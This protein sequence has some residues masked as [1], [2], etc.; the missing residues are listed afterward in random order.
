MKYMLKDLVYCTLSGQLT[1]WNP[2]P[3]VENAFH[4]GNYCITQY[5]NMLDAYE[6]LRQRLGVEDEDEDV[7]III[8]SLMSIENYLCHR[9]YDYG[10]FFTLHPIPSPE[11]PEQN[12]AKEPAGN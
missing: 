11:P 7:E 4:P 1:S 2:L 9:M 6:R 8:H 3:F 10:A 12:N 5:E